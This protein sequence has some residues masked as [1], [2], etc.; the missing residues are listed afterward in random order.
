MARLLDE[1]RNQRL[2][3]ADVARRLGVSRQTFSSWKERGLP[4]RRLDDAARALG[5][6]LEYLKTGLS[7]PRHQHALSEKQRQALEALSVFD[8]ED[9]DR[10][11]R[12]IFEE[13]DRIRRYSARRGTK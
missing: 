9:W 1:A 7:V 10:I 12:P 2:S 3:D 4:L 6:N 13:A 11:M 8:D 5:M